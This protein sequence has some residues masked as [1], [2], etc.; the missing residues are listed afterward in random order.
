MN[1]AVSLSLNV[2]RVDLSDPRKALKVD[3]FVR[4]MG[5]SL[6]HRPAWLLA[7]ERAT[8]QRATGFIIEQLGVVR[9]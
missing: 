7:V 2:E 1:V 9:G 8:G 6:F 4:E 3:N 5:A